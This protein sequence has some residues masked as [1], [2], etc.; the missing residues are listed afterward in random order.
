MI[1]SYN[2]FVHYNNCKPFIHIFSDQI[3]KAESEQEI[4]ATPPLNREYP[5]RAFQRPLTTG[6]SSSDS[7][8]QHH[9][10]DSSNLNTTPKQSNIS[11]TTKTETSSVNASKTTTNSSRDNS[12][13]VSNSSDIESEWVE[14]DEPGV[15]I[16]IKALANGTKE[17]KRVR[18]R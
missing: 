1:Y 12:L 10:R 8:D 18:F 11:A 15:Y 17:L 14:E 5:P 16:T 2:S 3:T 7:L 13:S 6:Y 4:P 9:F